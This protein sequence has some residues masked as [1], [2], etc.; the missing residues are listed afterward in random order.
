MNLTKCT[1]SVRL[2]LFMNFHNSFYTATGWLRYGDEGGNNMTQLIYGTYYSFAIVNGKYRFYEGEVILVEASSKKA[3]IDKVT[4]LRYEN[5]SK[6]FDKQKYA[7]VLAAS[8]YLRR[9]Y[10]V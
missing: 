1:D 3:F 5:L 8:N 6:K 10:N 9:S 7:R 4:D 2:V